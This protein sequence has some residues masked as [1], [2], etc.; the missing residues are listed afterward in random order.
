VYF[1]LVRLPRTSRDPSD[2]RRTASRASPATPEVLAKPRA[3]SSGECNGRWTSPADTD[4]MAARGQHDRPPGAD[5]RQL[6]R[7]RG[8]GA[9]GRPVTSRSSNTTAITAAR[10]P[11]RAGSTR[12]SRGT[13][14]A[15]A[16]PPPC[17]APASAWRSASCS[18]KRSS[19]G[20]CRFRIGR[21]VDA[22]EDHDRA[23]RPA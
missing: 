2:I 7:P 19:A 1:A 3:R 9:S 10:A 21:R 20:L 12:G 6:S 23:E 14:G 22:E 4:L 5:Q 18:F 16:P 8:R 11:A 13:H 15:S 17:R